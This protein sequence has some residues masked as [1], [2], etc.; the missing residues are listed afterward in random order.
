MAHI[1]AC[2]EAKVGVAGE[3]GAAS[4]GARSKLAGG[5]PQQAAALCGRPGRN[6]ELGGCV[7]TGMGDAGKM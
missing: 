7:H 3:Q 6:S 2:R 4:A 5:A 1:L